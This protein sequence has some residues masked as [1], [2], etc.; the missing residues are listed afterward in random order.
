MIGFPQRHSP[1]EPSMDGFTW[2]LSGIVSGAAVALGGLYWAAK[3]WEGR[4]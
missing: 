2:F 1:V 4:K 3:R